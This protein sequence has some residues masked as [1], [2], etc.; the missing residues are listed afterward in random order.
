LSEEK[1]HGKTFLGKRLLRQYHW[2]EREDHPEIHQKPGR[3]R[4]ASGADVTDMSL[5]IAHYGGFHQTTR[6]AGGIWLLMN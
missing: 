3:G 1:L 6:S 5:T 2:A 4:K